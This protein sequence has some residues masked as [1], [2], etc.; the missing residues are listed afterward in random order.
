M[1]YGYVGGGIKTVLNSWEEVQRLRLMNPYSSFR[2]FRTEEQAWRW[3]EYRRGISEASDVNRYG[4]VFF[5]HHIK[6]DYIIS[7]GSVYYNF[8]LRN[9]GR[10]ILADLPSNCFVENRPG[11][12]KVRVDGY[13]LGDTILDH[14]SAIMTGL[15]IVGP[16]IDVDIVVPDHSIFYALSMYDGNER[17]IIRVLSQIK[18]RLGNVA[19]TLRDF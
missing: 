1:F 18:S 5:N 11:I 7:K 2:K 3:V 17:R 16:F 6:L 4:D 8:R 10:L 14:L 12:I 15:E 9:L 19:L 13:Q